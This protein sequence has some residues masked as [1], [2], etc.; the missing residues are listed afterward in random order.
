MLLGPYEPSS[1]LR[2]HREL[3]DAVVVRICNVDATI[4]CHRD[5]SRVVELPVTR[6]MRAPFG[7]EHACGGELLV[8]LVHRF[9]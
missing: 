6:A 1:S 3:L 9:G 2:P 8:A 7:N 5:A 4:W